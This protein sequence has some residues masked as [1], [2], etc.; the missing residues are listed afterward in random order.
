MPMHFADQKYVFLAR[1]LPINGAT[2][3]WSQN[4]ELGNK[5]ETVRTQGVKSIKWWW[6]A[7]LTCDFLPCYAYSTD[8][9]SHQTGT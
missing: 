5:H 6:Q 3:S 8:E 1:K 4:L 2:N 9:S 7:N